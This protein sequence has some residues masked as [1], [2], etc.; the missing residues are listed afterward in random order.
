MERSKLLRTL[1]LK[2]YIKVVRDHI[3]D[4]TVVLSNKQQ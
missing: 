4:L 1:K 3:K 2:E